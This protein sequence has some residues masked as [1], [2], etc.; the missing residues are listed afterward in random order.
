VTQSVAVTRAAVGSVDLVTTSGSVEADEVGSATV[1]AGRGSVT[2]GIAEPGDVD[3]DVHSGSVVITLPKGQHPAT[4]L[5]AASGK[6]RCD[7]PPGVDGA[8]RVTARSGS[9]TVTER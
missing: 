8:V 5:H 1:H 2:L 3:V 4:D 6:V 7:C 9:V